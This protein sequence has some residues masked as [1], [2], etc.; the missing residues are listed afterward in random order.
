MEIND[1]I[2]TSFVFS[3]CVPER[4]AHD[5]Y[6]QDSISDEAP[7]FYRKDVAIVGN[8]RLS[9]LVSQSDYE[10]I[11][12]SINR[13]QPTPILDSLSDSE[14]LNSVIPT[15]CD[16]PSEIDSFSHA[17]YDTAKCV[18]SFER[19]LHSGSP[20]SSDKLTSDNSLRTNSD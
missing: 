16:R 17:L 1:S 6:I 5:D 8:Q 11:S 18:Q 15:R 10:N 7:I 19:D 9:T 20:S 3:D 12:S 4:T 13:F 14:L 2:I